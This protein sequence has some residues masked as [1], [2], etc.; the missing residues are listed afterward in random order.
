M[1]NLFCSDFCQEEHILIATDLSGIE[2]KKRLLELLEKNKSMPLDEFIKKATLIN[3][4]KERYPFPISLSKYD[5]QRR[6]KFIDFL[7]SMFDF[8]E[9]GDKMII[10]RKTE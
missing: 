2:L 1:N 10:I 3:K 6:R 8:I 9:S 5:H 4:E 7:K